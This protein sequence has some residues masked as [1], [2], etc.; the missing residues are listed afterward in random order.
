MFDD[1]YLF[2]K[3]VEAGNFYKAAKI[4]KIHHT[5]IQRRV[6]ALES[7][8]K[9]KLLQSTLYGKIDLTE[10]GRVL[11]DLQK[12]KFEEMKASIELLSETNKLQGD[13]SILIPAIL[14]IMFGPIIREF[15][16]QNP[17]INVHL[18]NFNNDVSLYDKPF[19]VALS[20]FPPS[21]LNYI[22]YPLFNVKISLYA[23]TEYIKVHGMPKDLD[24][25]KNHQLIAPRL[26]GDVV[27]NWQMINN[28]TKNQEQI[29]VI[30]PKASFD[31]SVSGTFLALAHQ[32]IAP[33]GD[34]SVTKEV[35]K[36]E[37]V[38]VLPEYNFSDVTFYAIKPYNSFNNKTKVFI[39]LLKERTPQTVQ[40]Y[41]DKD[42]ELNNIK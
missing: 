20:F 16:I 25:L 28:I 7:T 37:L 15:V 2:I 17:A 18:S 38:K 4:L 40:N 5:T 22:I 42:N 35:L 11:Y 30:N 34:I 9:I 26:N 12:F 1:I 13:F 10:D 23:S 36:K 19:D 3:L 14:N 39:D 29:S 6:K 24:D 32:G 27:L 21:N 33:L 8:L 31:G 41:E